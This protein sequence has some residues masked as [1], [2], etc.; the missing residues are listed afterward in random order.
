MASLATEYP[1]TQIW[2]SNLE[3]L[4]THFSFKDRNG[5]AQF[6]QEHPFLISVLFE[7]RQKFDRYF[8]PETLSSLEVFTDPE[9]SGNDPKLFALILTDLPTSDA[10]AR[11]DRL[12]QE[13][14]LSQP[15]EVKNVMNIDVEYVDGSI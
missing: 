1:E 7:A 9:D 6:L 13:W 12:D 15:Y 8:D 3:R 4:S 10:S 11:L 14:W 5:V 2:Q